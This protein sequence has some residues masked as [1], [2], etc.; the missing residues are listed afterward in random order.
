[1]N[2]GSC[3]VGPSNEALTG[4]GD[5]KMDGVDEGKD[6]GCA[7]A[8]AAAL[9]CYTVCC[10]RCSDSAALRHHVPDGENGTWYL[11]FSLIP[12]IDSVSYTHLTLPTIY[13]V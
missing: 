8:A 9:C 2:G 1:M 7:A 5:G 3:R 6:G 10:C 4:R 11:V 12:G 13:P